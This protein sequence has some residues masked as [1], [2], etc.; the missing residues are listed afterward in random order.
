M[1]WSLYKLVDEIAYE[2]RALGSVRLASL[3]RWGEAAELLNDEV[4]EIRFLAA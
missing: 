3:L 1:N 2:I 4:T